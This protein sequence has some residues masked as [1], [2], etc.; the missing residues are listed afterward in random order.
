MVAARI[1][2]LDW[3]VRS[4]RPA[5][6]PVLEAEVTSITQ[7]DAADMLSISERSVRAA[8]TVQREAVP[9]LIAAVESG[10]VS[11]SAAAEL[12]TTGLH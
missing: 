10:A 8:R 11:V 5:N 6:L 1:A 12:S 4:D 9:E 7:S 3:G 2:N